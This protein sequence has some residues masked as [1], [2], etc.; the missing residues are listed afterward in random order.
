MSRCWTDEAEAVHD[1]VGDEFGVVAADFAMMLVVVAAAVADV[2]C[3]SRRQLLRLVA[4]DEVHDVIGYQSGK[5]AN[6]FAGERDIVRNPDGRGSHDFDF[7]R[8]AACFACAFADEADA[9]FDEVGIGELQDY[10]VADAAGAAEGFGAVASDPDARRGA[11][12]PGEARCDAVVV[13]GFAGV[14]RAEIADEFLEI[15]ERGGVF[16]EDAAGT[17]AAA[18]AEVHAAAGDEIERGKEAGGDG[19][20]A[21]GG[22]G[23]TGAEKH[24]LRVGGPQR[25]R[26]EQRLSQGVWKANTG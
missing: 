24:A 16:A 22:G 26:R 6:A 18:D 20:G 9:P 2:G 25:G 7:G 4:G 12:G 19:G 1:F 17:V 21:D 11:I 5:P 3:E 8:V 10:A 13:N 23:G 14:E 15:F